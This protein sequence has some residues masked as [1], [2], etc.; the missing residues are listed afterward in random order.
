VPLD[1]ITIRGFEFAELRV[2]G[3]FF[4]MEKIP[5]VIP[6]WMNPGVGISTR[7]AGDCLSHIEVLRELPE[8]E[9]DATT[10]KS[11]DNSSVHGALRQRIAD[12]LERAVLE[13]DRQ[14]KVTAD[15]VF[16]FPTGMAAIYQT[17]NY[18]LRLYNSESKSVMF[19]FPF[20][21]TIHIFQDFGPGVKFF[22]LGTEIDRLEA[23]LL[24]ESEAGRRVQAVWTE[25]PS[26]PLL[27]SS[28][29]KRLR[30]LADRFLFALVVDDT[31]SSF[32][33]VDVLP[34]ADIIVTS[35][36]KSF[37]GY[38]DVMGGSAVLNPCS[39]LYQ[40]LKLTFQ[41]HF[42]NEMYS[43]DVAA[44]LTNSEDYLARSTIL[45]YNASCL[46]DYLQALAS[47]AN[48]SVGKVYYPSVSP[49]KSNYDAFMRP[50]AAEFSPGYGCLFSVE[51]ASIEATIAFYDNLHVHHG[52]HLGA[53]RTLAMPYV[54]AM[55][56]GSLEEVSNYNLRPTQIRISAGLES[57][58]TL[59]ETFKYA[60]E[61]A[62]AA[63]LEQI[64][65][66]NGAEN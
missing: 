52:P 55:Y 16:L 8:N 51:F 10:T 37:S 1:T 62:E 32:C 43:G 7:L 28:D 25:F 44:L 47:S 24:E 56:D 39:P 30:Q 4:P 5:L 63:T 36:T 19:G 40:K 41:E 12:L 45:N 23:F 22:Q 18:L 35:L 58:E 53:H 33:S 9:I 34:V 14:S 15:D 27:V 42:R 21:S 38:A 61:A 66:S 57:I 31:V 65:S 3:V 50:Q 2:F 11:L 49:T 54:R 6:F 20:H 48:S 64:S 60:V 59:L 46:V 29:L 17:H 26:N 13:P